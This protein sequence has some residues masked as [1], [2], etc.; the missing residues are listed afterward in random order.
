MAGQVGRQIADVLF[1]QRGNDGCHRT[2][3]ILA[4]AAFEIVKLLDQIVIALP[5]KPWKA[6]LPLQLGSV[7]GHAITRLC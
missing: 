5:G 4:L 6:A 3:D 1:A 2:T 7:A